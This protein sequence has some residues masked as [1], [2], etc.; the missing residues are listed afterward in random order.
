MPALNRERERAGSAVPFLALRRSEWTLV[1]YFA[2][3]TVLAH[4]LPVKPH[5]PT[6]TLWLNAAIAG[7]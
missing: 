2:Y 7:G 6:V 3:V 4:V 5:V 1:V